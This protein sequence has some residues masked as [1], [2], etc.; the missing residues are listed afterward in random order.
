M[1]IRNKIKTKTR[2]DGL[3]MIEP[4]DVSDWEQVSLEAEGS[5]EKRILVHPQNGKYYLLKFPNHGEF[6]SI[7]ER[8][9]GILANELNINHVFYHPAVFEG[10]YGVICKSFLDHT[11]HGNQDLW[12]MKEL[13]CRHSKIPNLN[14]HFGRSLL[15]SQE[16]NISYIYM[17][18]EAEF[19]S[20]VFNSFFEMNRI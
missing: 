5:R 6:E 13:V 9:N 4:N 3:S 17:I 18:L 8:F 15:V 20:R 12:H 19:G 1:K 11:N 16:H 10:R 14:E 7:T 2:Y